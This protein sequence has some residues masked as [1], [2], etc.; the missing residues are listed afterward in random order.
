MFATQHCCSSKQGLIHG[1]VPHT[2]APCKDKHLLHHLESLHPSPSCSVNRHCPSH[3]RVPAT[4]NHQ[5]MCHPTQ[6]SRPMQHAQADR[7]AGKDTQSSW[8]RLPLCMALLS[9]LN[10]T[11]E[12]V[13]HGTGRIQ[14]PAWPHCKEA[15]GSSCSCKLKWSKQASS[16]LKTQAQDR[17]RCPGNNNHPP[18]PRCKLTAVTNEGHCHGWLKILL[19]PAP[20]AGSCS[21]FQCE[22]WLLHTRDHPSVGQYG[23]PHAPLPTKATATA[24]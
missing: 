12:W 13:R 20:A 21:G 23:A 11:H 10:S 16:K 17:P 15:K 4:L 24:G 18:T 19:L 3:L 14:L 7:W 8:V 22:H 1:I 6:H 5:H 9:M 2:P